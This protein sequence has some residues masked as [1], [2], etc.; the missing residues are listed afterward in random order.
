M[1]WCDAVRAARLCM[2]MWCP[3]KLSKGLIDNGKW[4]PKICSLNKL[5]CLGAIWS[6]NLLAYEI[7]RPCP[8]FYKHFEVTSLKLLIVYNGQLASL[9]LRKLSCFHKSDCFGNYCLYSDVS[10]LFMYT[11]VVFCRYWRIGT[12]KVTEF[13]DELTY[14]VPSSGWLKGDWEQNLGTDR[15]V[16][17]NTNAYLLRFSTRIPS[18]GFGKTQRQM[19][20]IYVWKAR[21]Q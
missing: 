17:Q 9:Y 6:W 3:D 16:L 8:A 13:G 14:L 20:I 15:S 21:A 7:A 1:R 5:K 4:P 12:Y 18:E 19:L 2:K 10:C 11:C